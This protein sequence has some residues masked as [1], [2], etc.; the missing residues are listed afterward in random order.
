MVKTVQSRTTIW[1][2]NHTLIVSILVLIF[3]YF[4]LPADSCRPSSENQQNAS[5]VTTLWQY[6]NVY[7]YLFI[8]M[9][10]NPG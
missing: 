4:N 3:F 5:E 6:E 2:G 7:I 9:L 8:Y 10:S 1:L